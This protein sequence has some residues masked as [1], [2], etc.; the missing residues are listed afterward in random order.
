MI[1]LDSGCSYC[2]ISI[3]LSNRPGILTSSPQMHI[4]KD[5]G[6]PWSWIYNLHL[7]LVLSSMPTSLFSQC[8]FQ[9]VSSSDDC[10]F[11]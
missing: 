3:C 5:L 9:T 11:V 10:L 7:D 4:W 2:I 8:N 6:E 1:N